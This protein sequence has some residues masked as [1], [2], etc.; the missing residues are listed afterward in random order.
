CDGCIS[1]HAKGAAKQG[2]H[3]AEVAEAIGVT[4]LLH[5]GPATAHGPRAYNAFM[6]SYAELHPPESSA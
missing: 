1:A 4:L 6:E 3:P 5:G 2:A